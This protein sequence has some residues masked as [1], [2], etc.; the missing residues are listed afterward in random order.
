[1][2]PPLSDSP[3][4]PF[5]EAEELDRVQD[6]LHHSSHPNLVVI[7]WQTSRQRAR[8]MREIENRL[9]EYEYVQADFTGIRVVSL[10]EELTKHP[11][12]Q[13]VWEQP[14]REGSNLLRY[15]VHITGLEG[16]LS[17]EITSK[18]RRFLLYCRYLVILWSAKHELKN[19]KHN[20][21]R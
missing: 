4:L 20:A 9:P 12:M 16:T 7:T 1:M 6:F 10:M 21:K 3:A 8:L 2:N 13:P 11:A 18:E 15:V 17:V 14:R 19:W 5:L